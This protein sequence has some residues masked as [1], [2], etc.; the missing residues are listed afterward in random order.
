M[1]I[2][3]LFS[4][5]QANL[6]FPKFFNIVLQFFYYFKLSSLLKVGSREWGVG[7]RGSIAPDDLDV[8]TTRV[9]SSVKPEA[10]S[11]TVRP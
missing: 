10:L 11:D 2:N 5:L 4:G 9:H 8:E 1:C 7:Q 3:Y 6:T